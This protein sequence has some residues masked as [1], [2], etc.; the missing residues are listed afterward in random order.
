MDVNHRQ[1]MT[2]SMGRNM[3]GDRMMDEGMILHM[4]GHMTGEWYSQM[5]S[6][7]RQM[8]ILHT[9]MGQ[10]NMAE[11]N[12]R[13]TQMYYDMMDMIPGLDEPSKVPF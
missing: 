9:Q 7:H 4:Q 11:M 5:M 3:Q 10:N 12:S 8:A 1:M 6:L 2:V 13:L